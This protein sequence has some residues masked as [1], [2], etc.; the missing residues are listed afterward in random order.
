MK[1]LTKLTKLSFTTAGI[2]LSTAKASAL[3]GLKQVKRLELDGMEMEFVHGVRLNFQSA[4]EL[5]KFS[6]E[7]SLVLTAHG[8]YY[9]NLNATEKEKILASQQRIFETAKV[10]SIA[11]GFSITFHAG[12]YLKSSKEQTYK[13][14]KN[15]LLE[16]IQKLNSENIKI[17]IRPELTGKPTQFGDLDELISLS[18]EIDYVLPCID[19]AHF[20]ARENGKNNNEESFRNVFDKLE[21]NLGKEVLSNMHI[22]MSGINFSEKGER[23]HLPLEKSPLKWKIIMN[24]LKEYDVKGVVV[25]ESPN[26]EEDAILM[27]NYYNSL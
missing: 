20:I 17:W 15:S 22:H 1:L 10:T 11:K 21:K 4:V 3:E 14:I 19:F 24:L 7:N 8:P 27:K 13:I 9:I 26:I 25:S 16:I 23:N 6:E 12:F 18:Q 5:S 2:P